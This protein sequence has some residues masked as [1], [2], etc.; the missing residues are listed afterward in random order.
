MKS[1]IFYFA[2]LLWDWWGLLQWGAVTNL[3]Y[4]GRAL[5]ATEG[6]AGCRHQPQPGPG[7]SESM[8]SETSTDLSASGLRKA[9]PGAM[10]VPCHSLA[11][12][13]RTC[14]E[15]KISPSLLWSSF[16]PAWH[17]IANLISPM[18]T[19]RWFPF[20]VQRSCDPGPLLGPVGGRVSVVGRNC[21]IACR[22]L[23]ANS[24]WP[25][26]LFVPLAVGRTWLLAVFP[27][28]RL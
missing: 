17:A 9:N 5:T 26:Y 27:S 13:G 19:T 1:V 16:I 25:A 2:L 23:H 28:Q 14:M 10:A 20:R 11:C 24:L 12:P 7:R 21:I 6:T 8:E 4:H 22:K 3:N 15:R 18:T